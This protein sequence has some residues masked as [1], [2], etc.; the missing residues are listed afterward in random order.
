MRL[1]QFQKPSRYIG[2]EVNAIHKDASV[3]VALAFPD[4]YEVGM[5]HLGLRILYHV[6][7]GLSYASAERVFHPWAD[8][9]AHLRQHGLPLRSLESRRPLADFDVVGFSLQYELSCTSVLNMLSLSGIPL[10]SGRRKG[11]PLVIAGG[12]AAVNPAPMSPFI[13]AFLI[14]D[15][16]EAVPE[17]LDAV[18]RWKREGDGRRETLLGMLAAIEGV[19]VPSAAGPPH[20]HDGLRGHDA[21]RVRRRIIAS[22]EDAPYPLAP[23]VP[24]AQLVHDRVNIEIS[25]GC[26]MGCRFCQAGM[27]Y[28][29]LRERSPETIMRLAG[30]A[31][32]ATGYG[33]V[34]FTSLSAGD[35]SRLLPLI[36]GF[37]RRFS[38]ENCALSLP[39]L[40]VRAVNEEVLR[41]IKTVRKTGFTI[42]PEAATQRLRLAINKD[43]EEEDF[44]RAVDTLFRQGWLNLKLYYMIGL[45]TERDEDVEGIPLMAM[46]ALKAARRH[47]ARGANITVSVSS[48]VPKS[49]TPFQWCPQEGTNEL[50]RKKLFLRGAF[51]GK[52]INLK[53][54]DEDLSLLEAAFARGDER[55]SGLLIAAHRRGARLD[56]W[57]DLFNREAWKAAADET[58]IDFAT[59]AGKRFEP[60]AKTPL[61][62][63]HIET[64]ISESFLLKELEKSAALEKTP[65]CRR[66]CSACGLGCGPE[67]AMTG[68]AETSGTGLPGTGLPN[69]EAKT[70]PGNIAQA[71]AARDVRPGGE[72]RDGAAFRLRLEFSKT[73]PLGALSHRELMTAIGRAIKRAGLPLMYSKGFHPAPKISFGPPLGVGVRG[74]REY[75]DLAL[76]CQLPPDGVARLLNERL[77]EG[78]RVNDAMALPAKAPS[79]QNFISRY[80]Y[81]II[82]VN[83]EKALE[84]MKK[85]DVPVQRDGQRDGGGPDKGGVINI[86]RMAECVTVIREDAVELTLRDDISPVSADPG[87]GG[88]RVR[89]EEA[90]GAIFGLS[91]ADV[92]VTRTRLLGEKEGRWATPMEFSMPQP[93]DE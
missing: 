36:K 56:A 38:G 76:A 67:R 81:E 9:E 80:V 93:V 26:T 41:G 29:P 28:R 72:I 44:E 33:E 73:D 91:L 66:K 51:R 86:R 82:G 65:D 90:V 27:I 75:L 85:D 7:N 57:S 70:P 17:M 46:K 59:Y 19:Y 4:V 63:A 45:P 30:R 13:D 62:W 16:E 84:F 35:Y 31:L 14:G 71:A 32:A 34:S 88:P 43:F 89:L 6:I 60:G 79:L 25:R 37:N 40:R 18:F 92:D 55:L 49:H 77:P 58:G 1:L 21:P 12:P 61:P 69:D 87:A 48:F 11:G 54:H 10:E 68:E 78:I 47:A 2:G 50:A 64:G 15:G 23:V 83:P 52:P 20:D 53:G 8:F 22:L 24:Y 42:A 39:S 5:S 74:L 3:R